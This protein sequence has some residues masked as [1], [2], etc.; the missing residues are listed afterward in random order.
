MFNLNNIK[1]KMNKSST[2]IITQ[3]DNSYTYSTILN[4]EKFIKNLK[5]SNLKEKFKPQQLIYFSKN[6]KKKDGCTITK[7]NLNEKANKIGLN[8]GNTVNLFDLHKNKKSL[9][10]R[11][12]S[13]NK[14]KSKSKI[15]ENEKFKIEKVSEKTDTNMIHN[16]NGM[17]IKNGGEYK[18]LEEK[19]KSL[20]DRA[21][22][23]L[24][25]YETFIADNINLGK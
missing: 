17:I 13:K 4:T 11:G 9:T 7:D 18:N 10:S 1:P 23:L 3:S 8:K 24:S 20:Y 21:K 14:S 22:N 2:R 6:A 16:Q 25:N 15:N 19:M 5:K 12:N